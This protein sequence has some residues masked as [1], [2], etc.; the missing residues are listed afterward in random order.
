[1]TICIAAIAS[2][3]V[4]AVSDQRISYDDVFPATDRGAL[5]IIS[6]T[7]DTTW[8]LAF[9]ADDVAVMPPLVK[10]IS[11]D[12]KALK[13]DERTTD[14]VMDI[15]ANAYSDVR[16]SEFTARHLRAMAYRSLD[17]FKKDGLQDLGKELHQKHM[18]ALY[19]YDLGVELIIF[20][21]ADKGRPRLFTVA[22]PGRVVERGWQGF[23]AIGSGAYLAMGALHQKPI[24]FNLP[25]TV[26]RLLEAKFVSET[27]THVGESTTMLVLAANGTWGEITESEIK[28]VRAIWQKER[29]KS[30]PSAAKAEIEK[31]Q[32][33]KDAARMF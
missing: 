7:D 31:F 2:G 10:K 5:K 4:V 13:Q 27:A 8:F 32:V 3:A 30:I 11:S 21:H 25:G 29:A 19:R 14:A 18:D 15:A 6:L 28:K 9:S 26:Y 12:L 16:E 24:P 20:T 17:E 33:V 1:M 23:A 22:N